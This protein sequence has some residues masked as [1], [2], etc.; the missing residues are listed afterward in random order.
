[1]L[2]L[3]APLGVSAASTLLLLGVG[4][5]GPARV[6]A[7][8]L[9]AWV[10]GFDT[11]LELVKL[12]ARRIHRAGAALVKR[13]SVALWTPEVP[14]ARRHAFHHGLAI[15]VLRHAT[16]GE[17]L[18]GLAE[19]IRPGG[20]LVLQDLVLDEPGAD[21]AVAAWCRLERRS[22][23]IPTEADITNCLCALGLDVR[24]VEDQSARH[25]RLALQ[26]WQQMLRGLDGSRPGLAQAATMV[27]EAEAWMRRLR[28]IQE[29]RIRLVRWNAI[30]P[31]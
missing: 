12:A 26:G 6:L 4:A 24:V 10:C 8:D 3:A 13:A 22:T 7:A 29:G 15:D 11:D 2:R 31:G 20:Q 18:P 16:F 19:V 28:L 5:G 25:A 23:E 14:V 17:I 30:I 21:A 27:A 1:M 9:G